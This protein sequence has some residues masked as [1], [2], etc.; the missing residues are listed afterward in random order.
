MTIPHKAL[1]IKQDITPYEACCLAMLV[2][3]VPHMAV[4]LPFRLSI[5][6]KDVNELIAACQR[7]LKEI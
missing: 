1:D 3:V 7:H 4:G 5:N 2:S 6:E